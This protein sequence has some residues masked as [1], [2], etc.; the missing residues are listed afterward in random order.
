MPSLCLRQWPLPL[1]TLHCEC[2][3]VL[4][5]P[6]M[7][8]APGLGYSTGQ[9]ENFPRISTFHRWKDIATWRWLDINWRLSKYLIQINVPLC[10]CGKP[11]HALT[12]SCPQSRSQTPL[13]RVHLLSRI[14]FPYNFWMERNPNA[15]HMKTHFISTCKPKYRYTHCPFLHSRLRYEVF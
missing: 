11:F 9:I 7:A 12:T 1:P 10:K 13:A 3:S 14:M 2:P 6:Y 4:G 8:L 15:F 5:S